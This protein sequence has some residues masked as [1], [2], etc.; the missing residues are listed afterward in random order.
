MKNT[1]VYKIWLG[2]AS[3]ET[4]NSQLYGC[5]LIINQLGSS[6]KNIKQEFRADTGVNLPYPLQG[7]MLA[8]F[9][10]YLVIKLMIK[11]EY[12]SIYQ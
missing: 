2:V 11:L 7:K 5:S 4:K 1:E 10:K 3:R 12:E 6:W 8:E 9:R